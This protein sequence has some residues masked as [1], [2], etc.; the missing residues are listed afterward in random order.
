M[1]VI[2]NICL[3]KK[4]KQN[5]NFNQYDITISI[6]YPLSTLKQLTDYVAK[7]ALYFRFYE[8]NICIPHIP[9]SL[10]LVLC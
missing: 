10:K 5:T 2:S 9:F 1:P 6:Y 3:L 4:C 8:C 7:R